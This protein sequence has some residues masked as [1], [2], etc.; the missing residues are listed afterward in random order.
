MSKKFC[1]HCCEETEHNKNS[2]CLKC[3]NVNN[4]RVTLGDIFK[5]KF[6]EIQEQVNAN[7]RD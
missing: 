4:S 6:K 7:T 5:D 1:I 3:N 2:M